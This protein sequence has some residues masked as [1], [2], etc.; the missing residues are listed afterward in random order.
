MLKADSFDAGRRGLAGPR[1][2]FLA[3]V[4]KRGKREHDKHKNDE[5]N[6]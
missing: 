2:S 6:A 1:V 3:T 4:A 5:P